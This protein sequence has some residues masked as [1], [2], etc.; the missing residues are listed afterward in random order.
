MY[1]YLKSK[2]VKV[3]ASGKSD[4]GKLSWEDNVTEKGNVSN[5]RNKKPFVAI[6]FSWTLNLRDQKLFTSFLGIDH[7]LEKVKQDAEIFSSGSDDMSSDDTD[8]NPDELEAL[9]ARVC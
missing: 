6:S 4:G 1:D 9:S 8:F 7:H 3:T 5:D 2:K